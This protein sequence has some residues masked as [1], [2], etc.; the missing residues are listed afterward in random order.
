MAIK[1]LPGWK[2]H[3]V[4]EIVD[5][6][7]KQVD[8][9]ATDPQRNVY[10]V[11]QLQ[12]IQRAEAKKQ[13]APKA[14]TVPRRGRRFTRQDVSIRHGRVTEIYYNTLDEAQAD[15]QKMY[16]NNDIRITPYELW[17]I[18]VIYT[19][20]I[21]Q[22]DT[23]TAKEVPRWVELTENGVTK[24]RRITQERA[25]LSSEYYEKWDLGTRDDGWDNARTRETN[26]TIKRIV[27]FGAEK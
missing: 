8:R 23:N 26:F 2:W 6:K 1:Y 25:A 11:R 14:P 16:Q 18:Q 22:R 5:G 3:Y 24:R 19:G 13:G 4:Y 12:D 17:Y 27:L 9:F 21:A 15:F 20:M 7:R 10:T